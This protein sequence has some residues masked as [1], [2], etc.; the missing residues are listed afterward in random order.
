MSICQSGVG[1]A[2][3]PG[4]VLIEVTEEHPLIRLSEKLPWQT[5]VDTIL[6]DLKKTK[7]GFWWLGRKLRVR[8]HLGVYLLHQL[9]NKTDRQIE[10]NVVIEE[11]KAAIN[12]CNHLSADF[13][14]TA[15]WGVKRTIEQINALAYQYIDDVSYFL[16]ERM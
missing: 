6:P 12:R 13:I 11:T 8:T 16:T 3:R 1:C 14:A 4:M 15:P 7:K 9:F 10:Y 5:L 2:V